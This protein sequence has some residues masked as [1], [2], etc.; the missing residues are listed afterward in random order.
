MGIHRLYPLIENKAPTAI[1]EVP[2]SV[3][4]SKSL[5]V[6]A[7]KIIYQFVVSTTNIQA[8]DSVFQNISELTDSEGN[9]TGH[10]MGFI[11]K[12][13]LMLESGIKPVWVFD[14]LPPEQ[15]RKEL[16]RRKAAKQAAQNQAEEAK[17]LGDIIEEQYIKK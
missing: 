14:G 9:L 10:L 11:Y 8:K 6:D 2:I 17:E 7:S 16:M 3:F 12:S 1:K 5:A 4:T 15:K 13:L